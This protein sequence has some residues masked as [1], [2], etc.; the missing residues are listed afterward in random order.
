[1]RPVPPEG[2]AVVLSRRGHSWWRVVIVLAIVILPITAA[3]SQASAATIYWSG[4]SSVGKQDVDDATGV[5]GSGRVDSV[6]SDCIRNWTW[7][8]NSTTYFSPSSSRFICQKPLDG[9]GT[10]STL[11][12]T[13]CAG[14]GVGGIYA[15]DQY[16]YWVC[17]DT[18]SSPWIGRVNVDGTNSAPHFSATAAPDGN[19]GYTVTI[20][21][22]DSWLYVGNTGVY[23]SISRYHIDGSGQ[24]TDFNILNAGDVR[25]IQVDGR[26]LYWATNGGSFIAR[27]KPNGTSVNKTWLASGGGLYGIAL[28]GSAL[29]WT[30]TDGT[31]RRADLDGSNAADL[32]TGASIT[33]SNEHAQLHVVGGTPRLLPL[34]SPVNTV[35]PAVSGTAQVGQALTADS[36]TWSNPPADVSGYAYRWQVSDDG[37]NGW[38][39]A[40]GPGGVTAT[41]TPAA[42]EYAKFLRVEVTAT[43]DGGDTAATSSATSAVLSVAPDNTVAPAITGTVQVDELLSVDSG[44]WQSQQLPTGYAYEWQ[45]SDD[46]VSG[47]TAGAGTG[48]ATSSYIAP[49]AEDGK[50]L[51]VK[52]TATNDAGSTEAFTA[53]TASVDI[54]APVNLTA[55]SILG[56]AGVGEVLTASVGTWNAYATQ[57]A[58]YQWQVSD[59]GSTGWTAAPGDGADSNAYTVADADAG[60]YLRVQLTAH[61]RLHDTVADSDATSIVLAHPDNTALP[62]ISGTA[63]IGQQLTASHGTWT[64]GDTYAYEWQVSVDGSTGWATAT[65][66]GANTASYTV[67]TA[68]A[69]KYL[70]VVVTASN[71]LFETD[72]ESAATSMVPVPVPVVPTPTPPAVAEPQ[73]TP[74]PVVVAPGISVGETFNSVNLDTSTPAAASDLLKGAQ[75]NL[76]ASA[77]ITFVASSLPKGVRLVGGKLVADTP[78]TYVVRVKVT[79][80][81]G[82]VGTRRVKIKVG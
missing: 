31:I 75:V 2:H 18:N 69:G 13:Q 28:T 60:K 66:S 25:S 48:V 59:N 5:L 26:H 46:G 52:V 23:S 15:T 45:V 6:S 17:M 80:K 55:P 73:A 11:V 19:T 39:N 8:A 22:S 1:M 77:T 27:A 7:A 21:G 10:E 47:W 35:A 74:P 49:V 14:L 67:A 82:K 71:S 30:R 41:Y 16:V 38:T 44:T 78:G 53:V 3:A 68:D 36:G 56:G 4:N 32:I 76:P 33:S 29:Y 12:D 61:N 9:S 64:N 54:P 65:G 24:D 20:T 42:G 70:R 79:R 58:T 72:Q 34:P 43:N 51:R 50:Y 62:T 81:N 40:A 63:A 57:A 37:V